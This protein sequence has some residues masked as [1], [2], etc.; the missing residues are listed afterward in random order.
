MAVSSA[1]KIILTASFLLGIPFVAFSFICPTQPQRHDY[2]ILTGNIVKINVTESQSPV[3]LNAVRVSV[4]GANSFTT[5]NSEGY[6]Y[7]SDI[8]NDKIKLRFEYSGSQAYYDLG[9]VGLNNQIVLN[10]ITIGLGKVDV[11][12]KE[13]KPMETLKTTGTIQ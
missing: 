1:K 7:L 6:F 13:I 3:P 12:L 8:W 9:Q 10:D 5:A 2:N 4:E 11:R